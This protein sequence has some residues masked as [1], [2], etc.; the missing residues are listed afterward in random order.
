MEKLRD[1]FLRYVTYDTQ[2]DSKA[3]VKPSTVGQ[4]VFLEMLKQELLDMGL[5]DVTLDE[6]GY[7]MATLEATTDEKR[8]VVAFM[9]HVDTSPE[10]SGKGVNPQ[11]I[12]EYKGGDIELGNGMILGQ[13]EF[14]EIGLY[15]GQDIIT[16]DGTT[17]L[18]ADDKAGVASIMDMA[19]YFMNNPIIEHGKVRI[20]FTPDEEIGT[21]MDLFDVSA[22]GANFAYTIDGGRVG[23]MEY[24]SFNA[25][26]ATIHIKG[27]NVHPG[28][29]KGKMINATEVAMRLNAML[30]QRERPQYT[31]GY[32]GYYHLTGIEGDVEAVT[33]RYIIRDHNR[34]L[35]EGRKDTLTRA[36]EGMRELYGKDVMSIEMRDQYYNMREVIEKQ[37]KVVDIAIEA[38]KKL[39]IEP[40][41]RPIRGGTD[42][43]R[44]SFM[45]VPTPNLFAGGE[46]FHSRYEF[47]PCDSLKKANELIKEIV[48]SIR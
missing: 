37:S 20:V 41:V 48:K 26:E 2:S 31:E 24:E 36:V 3:T 22:I 12:K 6:N 8:D 27:R 29:A 14:P 17:L 35:F 44:L 34:K 39:N 40:S 19:Q 15:I 4:A 43:A 45:G 13:E 46:N 28:Y 38:M 11:I 47:L 9:A 32:E 1:R 23:E 25:A 21:G 18:G 42:G 30:P 33:V 16:T 5:S 7:L 10:V